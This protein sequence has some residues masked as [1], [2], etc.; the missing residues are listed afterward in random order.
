MRWR[1][2]LRRAERELGEGPFPYRDFSLG[3]EW[4]AEQL[5]RRLG[6]QFPVVE[7]LDYHRAGLVKY[8]L[9][10][11]AAMFIIP[12]SGVIGLAAIPFVLF[13]FYL[14]E[15]HFLFLFPLI[16][17]GVENPYL[18]SFRMSRLIGILNC[19]VNIIPIAVGML[20]GLL[21]AKDPFR[22]WHVGCLAVVIWYVDYRKHFGYE[23]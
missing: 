15:A 23:G 4:M 2:S 3:G 11:S 22:G 17:Q 1:E 13:V 9:S 18:A 16:A 8:G 10:M 5:R 6:G 14:V 20:T 12:L 7:K 19:I 21:H